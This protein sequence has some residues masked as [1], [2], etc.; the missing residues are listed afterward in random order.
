MEGVSPI[1]AS[2]LHSTL[3]TRYRK[4]VLCGCFLLPGLVFVCNQLCMF[5]S[6]L[7]DIINGLAGC[8]LRAR[9]DM[10]SPSGKRLVCYL[11]S[12]LN[13]SVHGQTGCGG[14]LNHVV[15]FWEA[16]GAPPTRHQVYL[17]AG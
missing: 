9:D 10:T 8:L 12:F 6:L 17:M 16:P 3:C 11:F 2:T 4:S 15:S 14:A 5:A 1:K 13:Y 7:Q